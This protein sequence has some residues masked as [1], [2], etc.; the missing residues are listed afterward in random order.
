[1]LYMEQQFICCT[2]LLA[3][4]LTPLAPA[5]HALHG[6]LCVLRT[7]SSS[8]FPRAAERGRSDLDL[9]RRTAGGTQADAAALRERLEQMN[10]REEQEGGTGGRPGAG[11]AGQGAGGEGGGDGDGEDVLPDLAHDEDDDEVME[12]DDYYQ[13]GGSVIPLGMSQDE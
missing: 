10:K 2:G 5:A 7:T 12:H 13:V 9:F 1:M 4:S 11:G 3:C 6:C 8:S